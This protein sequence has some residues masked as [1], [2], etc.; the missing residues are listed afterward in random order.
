[1]SFFEL[2]MIYAVSW[3][4]ILFMVLP[5]GVR[6]PHTPEKG[7]A[8]SAPVNPRL[9]RKLLITS[10]IALLPPLGAL[11]VSEAQA[12]SG[13][14][15]AGSNDCARAAD[16]APDASINATDAD[17]TLNPAQG[18]DKV[19]VFLDAPLTDYVGDEQVNRIG[20]GTVG[21]G[22]ITTDTKTGETTLN[23]RP[24]GAQATTRTDCK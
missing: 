16:I 5:I 15:H 24:I 18:F 17:A 10:V 20:F 6:V 21:A 23:G 9:R 22:V 3:W 19:P 2:F 4:L 11:A 7:H 12:A 14:Y 8:A 1:M 13:I